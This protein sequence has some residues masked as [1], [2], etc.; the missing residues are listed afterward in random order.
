MLLQI[1]VVLSEPQLW[2]GLILVYWPGLVLG[3]LHSLVPCYDKT[4]FCFY[5]FGVSRQ[6]KEAF[7]ILGS[8]AT[9]TLLSNMFIGTVI[10][11]LGSLLLKRID[12][13]ISNQ[14]GALFMIAV[15]IYLLVQVFR[16]KLNP[17]SRQNEGIVKRFQENG[18]KE[19]VKTGFVLGI[20]AGLTPCL[21]E[22]AIFTYG[23]SIGIKNGVF[24]VVAYALGSLI[25]LFPFAV[26]G[27]N[28]VRRGK[29]KPA[30]TLINPKISKIEVVSVILLLA[31]GILL[32]SFAFAGINIFGSLYT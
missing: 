11:A 32:F 28:R 16:R 24:L 5:V 7:R 9:G 26:F 1:D 14:I 21:F 13:L 17:H 12:P 3:L 4:M 10:A 15:G 6:N 2:T 27:V 25:G 19:R 29:L 22:I 18:E 30:R 31:I 20:I 8:Y 23:A